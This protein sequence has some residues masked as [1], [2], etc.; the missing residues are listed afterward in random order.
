MTSKTMKAHG[1]AALALASSFALAP[2]HAQAADV[3]ADYIGSA[4]MVQAGTTAPAKTS[5]AILS[6]SSSGSVVARYAIGPVRDVAPGAIHLVANMS[7]PGPGA[8]I[9]ISLMELSVGKPGEFVA[10]AF[11]TAVPVLTLSSEDLKA[12]TFAGECAND[13]GGIKLDFESKVYFIQAQLNWDASA[14]P[15][16]PQ[17]RTVPLVS[18]PAEVCGGDQVPTQQ[19][20]S[21]PDKVFG[22]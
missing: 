19:L 7:D 14:Q 20:I 2:A 21:N 16:A 13:G 1:L 4:G 15:T 18:Y 12:G 5:R 8:S 11:A 6:I 22:L 17:L 3:I 10:T 9:S